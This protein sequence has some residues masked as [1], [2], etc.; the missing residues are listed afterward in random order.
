MNPGE[1]ELI[2]RSSLNFS[3]EIRQYLIE[4][5]KWGKF[6][7][8]MG[9]IGIGLMTLAAIFMIASSSLF[10]DVEPGF[11]MGW[12]GGF[13]LLIALLYFFPVRYLHKFSD[14][15]KNGISAENPEELTLGFENL[16]S[17]FKFMGI[18]TIVMVS[19][20]ILM[21]LGMIVYF[22]TTI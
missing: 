17:L 1:N 22:A 14:K 19:F 11:N 6:L 5:T 12:M 16:K 15:I 7:T 10:S 18:A 21:V 20:Y 3:T 4:T 2:N 8:I 13:Y 9:Y